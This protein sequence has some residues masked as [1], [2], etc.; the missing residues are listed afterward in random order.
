MGRTSAMTFTAGLFEALRAAAW[1]GEGITRDSYGIGESAVLDMIEDAARAHGLEIAGTRQRIWSLL[2]QGK[3]RICRF[4][5]AALI[6]IRCRKG[7]ISTAP[8][9]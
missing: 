9:G 7:E 6:W 5:P 4:S 2:Y 1:D 8:R 3:T